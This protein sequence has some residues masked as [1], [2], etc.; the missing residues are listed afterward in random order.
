MLTHG[1]CV[2][3]GSD[4]SSKGQLEINYATVSC[5]NFK[6]FQNLMSEHKI[7]CGVIHDWQLSIKYSSVIFKGFC[8]CCYM[9]G[10]SGVSIANLLHWSIAM[11]KIF[12]KSSMEGLIGRN[13]Y[14]CYSQRCLH[15]LRVN[16]SS[17]TNF[18]GLTGI[19]W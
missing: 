5:S 7:P 18:L 12:Y 16:S 4:K 19:K 1:V 11:Y 10:S 6:K 13:S 8:Y 3:W 2:V 17:V 15:G 9:F 14:V